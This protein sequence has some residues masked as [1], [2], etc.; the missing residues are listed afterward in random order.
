MGVSDADILQYALTLEHLEATFY[1]QALA[2]FTAADFIK[3]GYKNDTYER[4]V[5][6]GQQC[7]SS[8]LFLPPFPFSSLPFSSLLFNWSL[9]DSLA[10]DADCCCVVV[11][12]SCSENQHVELLTGGL[13][14]AGAKPVQECVYKFP[15]TD[16]KG[17]MALSQVIEGVGVSAYEGA[18]Q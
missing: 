3:A 2:N 4:V 9:V 13:T 17:F 16:V 10:P 11:F 6:I 14:A 1:R 8:S 7:V 12:V 18:A 15:Y 5:Q